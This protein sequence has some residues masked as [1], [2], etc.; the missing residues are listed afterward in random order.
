MPRSPCSPRPWSA[1]RSPTSPRRTG[2]LSAAI[3]L[4]FANN[5][6]AM[7]VVALPSPVSGLALWLSGVDPGDAAGLRLM[8]LADL[9]ATLLAWAAGARSSP[10]G[11][12]IRRVR[13]LS[14]RT[15]AA[16]GPA[17]A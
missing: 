5:V 4:H 3:G 17:R 16:E 13:V 14:R 2:N 1:W 11:D 12:C 8:M 7:L 6:M 9:A 10:G 15:T